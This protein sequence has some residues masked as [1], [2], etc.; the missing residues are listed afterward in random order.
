MPIAGG[1]VLG[2]CLAVVVDAAEGAV[3]AAVVTSEPG[4]A[5]VAVVLVVAE[6]VF[7]VELEVVVVVGAVVEDEDGASKSVSSSLMSSPLNVN[8]VLRGEIGGGGG[9]YSD[10]VHKPISPQSYKTI[11]SRRT[12]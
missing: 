7:T 9:K 11:C 5:V 10:I 3:V 2:V 8:D 1:A 6:F 12:G 4:V